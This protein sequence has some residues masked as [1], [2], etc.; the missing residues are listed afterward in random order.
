V[1][2]VGYALDREEHEMGINCLAIPLFLTSKVKPDGA[3][4][5]TAVAQ[6]LPI[7]EP[8]SVGPS[9]VRDMVRENL[10][11]VIE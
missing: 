9:R 10:G 8:R 5:I 11:E 2:A 3:M 6:R 1:R 7:E 4:S